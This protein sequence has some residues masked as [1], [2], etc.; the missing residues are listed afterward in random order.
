MV[1]C[2]NGELEYWRGVSKVGGVN[3][4]IVVNEGV[5]YDGMVL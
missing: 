5:L 4:W 2:V 3:E 1:G